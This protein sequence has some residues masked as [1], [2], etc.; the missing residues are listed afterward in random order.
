RRAG[1]GSREG[2]G[3]VFRQGS[4]L[5][6]LASLAVF[7]LIKFA[8]PPFLGVAVSSAPVRE[9]VNA[10]LQ[11]VAL[12]VLFE[13]GNHLFAVLYIGLGRTRVLIASSAIL[14]GTNVVLDYGLIFGHFGLPRMGI[15]GS[16]WGTAIAE[17]ASFLFLAGY[18][19]AK[20]DVRRYRLA[21]GRGWDGHLTRR[22]LAIS[23]P[24][25]LEG[26]VESARWF[27]LFAIVERLGEVA[28]GVSSVVYSC[29]G[30]LIIPLEG[31][32]DAVCSGV[33]GV[34]GEGRASRIGTL[35]RRSITL[36][37]AV[38]AVPALLAA[39]AP[40]LVL[41]A[42]TDDPDL[43][44]GSVAPLRVV[45]LALLSVTPGEMLLGA[46]MGTGDTRGAFRI[47]AVHA[48]AVLAFVYVAGI[49]LRQGEA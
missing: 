10:F 26:L 33:S 12:G 44:A 25:A 48:V 2:V 9:A 47:Q 8:V 14:A 43:V 18:A 42:F 28:L 45:S 31:I 6:L 13:V 7:L 29:Y 23:A 36:G 3:V 19:L 39:V 32:A 22:L 11:I 24:A 15:V 21:P 34:I 40:E 37:Y 1:R 16:A 46:V 49:V 20:G 38:V 41:A 17:C 30:L 5:L 4:R 35:L 27:V